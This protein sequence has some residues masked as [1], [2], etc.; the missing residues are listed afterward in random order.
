M[1]PCR[2]IFETDDHLSAIYSRKKEIEKRLEQLTGRKPR[3]GL[4][5]VQAFIIPLPAQVHELM[6]EWFKVSKAHE[7][8]SAQVDR[9]RLARFQRG[10]FEDAY[11]ERCARRWWQRRY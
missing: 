1:Q 5:E 11:E 8:R 9:A 10:A 6:E 4:S 7:E 3:P 2:N